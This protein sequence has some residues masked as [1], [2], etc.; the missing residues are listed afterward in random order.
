MTDQK[1]CTCHPAEAPAPCQRRYAFSEC[2]D[3]AEAAAPRSQAETLA[4]E[5]AHGIFYHSSDRD[6]RDALTL[7]LVAFA[8]EIRRSAIEP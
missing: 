5:V 8:A 3:V 1:A 6:K 7:A 4:A 2:V